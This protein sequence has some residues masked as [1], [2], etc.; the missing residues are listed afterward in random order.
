MLERPGKILGM[1]FWKKKVK[2]K[3]KC[4]LEDKVFFKVRFSR[5]VPK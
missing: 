1:C 5:I 4:F 2:G 3:R